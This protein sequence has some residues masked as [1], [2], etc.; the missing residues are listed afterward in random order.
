[1]VTLRRSTAKGE[2]RQVT[3]IVGREMTQTSKEKFLLLIPMK[4]PDQM[5]REVD[6]P[7]QKCE[8]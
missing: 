4:A 7:S 1:M 3:T 5:L 8:R 6:L 2:N